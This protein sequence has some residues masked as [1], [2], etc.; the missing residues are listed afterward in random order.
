MRVLAAGFLDVIVISVVVVLV[1]LQHFEGH[2]L[3]LGGGADFL[4]PRVISV[5]L[6]LEE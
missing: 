6:H 4:L 5:P 3:D 2:L 1:V